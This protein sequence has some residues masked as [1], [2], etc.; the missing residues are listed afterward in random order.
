M[1]LTMW[2]AGQFKAIFCS[3][4]A[5]VFCMMSL[6]LRAILLPVV[7]KVGSSLFSPRGLFLR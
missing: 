4:A 3:S 1:Q 6:V 7:L 5:D 2:K